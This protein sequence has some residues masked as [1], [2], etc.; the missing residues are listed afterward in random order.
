MDSI[1]KWAGGKRQLLDYLKQHIDLKKLAGHKLFEPFVGGGA[2]FLD[3]EHDHVVIN[4]INTELINVYKQIK[5]NPNELINILQIHK[6]KHCHDYYYQIRNIDRTKKI[7]KL[8]DVEKAARTIY[9]NRVCY[10]GLYRVNS[11]GEFNVPLGRYVNPEIVFEEK[12]IEISKYL[13]NTSIEIRNVDFQE[14]V[15]DAKEGDVIY[16]DPP[17][18]YEESG[19]TSYTSDRFTREDLERLKILCDDLIDRGCSV[20][21]SNN[22]TTYVNDLFLDNKYTI[23]HVLAKRMINCKGK[24]REAVHEVIIYG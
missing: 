8:S 15:R 16:F 2:L 24:K 5:K 3:L 6:K 11:K 12:L 23:D 21:L 22:D 10:N 19:F 7:N 18:D 1:L 13:N 17:Y 4:D 14:A 9:L 20:I